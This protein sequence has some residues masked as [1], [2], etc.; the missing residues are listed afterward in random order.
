MGF[1]QEESAAALADFAGN[2]MRLE[3]LELGTIKVINDAY[4]ANPSSMRAAADVLADFDAGGGRRVMIA[5]DMRELGEQSPALHEQLGREL[6]ARRIDLVVGV[7]ELGRNIAAGAAAAGGNAEAFDSVE[8]AADALGELLR[9]LD[10]V[11]IKGSRA[12]A[13]ERLLTP[14]KA[15]CGQGVAR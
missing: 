14:L 13:M 3:W 11:L 10:V 5:G 12:M 1:T 6:G 9:P 8:A 7:G 2:D 4:N 15:A